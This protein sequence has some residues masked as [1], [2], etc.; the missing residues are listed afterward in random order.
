MNWLLLDDSSIWKQWS[1]KW[2]EGKD[3]NQ[4]IKNRRIDKEIN[5]ERDLIPSSI[6]EKK[7]IFTD[8]LTKQITKALYTRGSNDN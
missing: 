1:N 8:W 6:E 3:E 4:M 2:N 5:E 7:M